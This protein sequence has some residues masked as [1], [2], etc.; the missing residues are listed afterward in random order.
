MPAHGW[1]K[2]FGGAEEEA[3]GR[4]LSKKIPEGAYGDGVLTILHQQI[5][6]VTKGLKVGDDPKP[7]EAGD[8][9]SERKKKSSGKSQ[10]KGRK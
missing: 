7:D 2:K 4:H 6:R 8:N 5:E 10:G 1:R 9:P 3:L